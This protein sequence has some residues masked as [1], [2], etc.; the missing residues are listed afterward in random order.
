[1]L[2][3]YP[4]TDIPTIIRPQNEMMFPRTSDEIGMIEKY[5]GPVRMVTVIS[6]SKVK[7]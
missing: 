3:G 7:T 2:F 5:L 6:D 1:L 4:C